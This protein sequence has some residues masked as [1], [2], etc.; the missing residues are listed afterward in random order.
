MERDLKLQILNYIEEI[1]KL[2]KR[3]SALRQHLIKLLYRLPRDKIP[4]IK[5]PKEEIITHKTSHISENLSSSPL[6]YKRRSKRLNL[7][8]FMKALEESGMS[9][10]QQVHQMSHMVGAET[11]CKVTVNGESISIFQYDNPLT[12]RSSQDAVANDNLMMFKEVEHRDWDSILRVFK[13]L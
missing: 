9:V 11:G 12:W 7:E 13:S 10:G 6:R 4:P 3:L 2:G 1:D 5:L 8:D